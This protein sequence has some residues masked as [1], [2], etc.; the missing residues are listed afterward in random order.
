MITPTWSISPAPGSLTTLCGGRTLL[1]GAGL[2]TG[3]N[4]IILLYNAKKLPYHF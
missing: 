1:G 3:N 4:K 2:T